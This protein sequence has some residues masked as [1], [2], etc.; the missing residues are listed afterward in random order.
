MVYP[1]QVMRATELEKWDF[2][3]ST[4]F[5]H[6]VEK[7]KTMRGKRLRQETVRFY[8]TQRFLKSGDLEQQERGGESV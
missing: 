4:C 6:T 3:V 1:K 8:L 5:M 7:D 2:R